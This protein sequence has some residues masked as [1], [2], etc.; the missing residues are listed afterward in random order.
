MKR[1]QLLL[2]IVIVLT[3]DGC[4]FIKNTFE[5]KDKTKEFVETLIKEDYN[6]SIELMAMEHE[7]A[8]N[9]NLDT[10]KAG[11]ARFRQIFVD[12]WGT[13]LEYS[14]I[15]SEKTFST[16][17]S[18]NNPPNTTVVLVEF[19]NDKDLGIFQILFDDNSKK[20]LHIRTL[21]V[22]E[23]IPTMTW[24][25]LFGI[26]AICVPIFNIYVIRKVR[27]SN[28]NKKWLK[29]IAIIFLNVPSIT[30]AAIAGLSFKIL[31]FQFLLG[32]S[33]AYSGFYNSYWTF[34]IPLG[35]IYWFWK[36]RNPIY[37]SSLGEFDENTN[38]EVANETGST[39][40]P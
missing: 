34:G 28:L 26:I 5:Y 3:L 29:Y 8:R 33:F 19:N 7:M 4:E 35:G 10:M 39:I 31:N 17:E 2:A 9:S 13:E 38:T 6:K 32:I 23:P 37:S 1:T 36:L 22:K 21:E 11:L 15:K 16:Y 30:Y 24:F 12:N 40:A 18:Q 25:W 27:R 20:I 14:F